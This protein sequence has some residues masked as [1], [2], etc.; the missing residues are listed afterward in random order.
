MFDFANSSFTTIIITVVFSVYFVN[1]IAA[2]SASANFLWSLANFVSQALV[3]LTAPVLGAIADF[4][5]AKKKFLFASY[6][7]CVVFTA[8]LYLTGPGQVALALPLFIIAN[9]AY[10]SGENLIASFLPEIAR[11]QDMGKISGFGWALGFIGGVVSL[12]LCYSFIKGGFTLA[13]EHNVR[14]TCLVTAGF[15]LLAGIPTFFW[16]KERKQSE[17]LPPG[18]SHVGMGCRRIRDTFQHVR[19]FRELF[20]FLIIFCMYNCGVTTVVVFASIYAEQV[21]H[22]QPGELIIFFLITLRSHPGPDRS[23]KDDL[24]HP[25]SVARRHRRSLLDDRQDRLLCRRQSCRFGNRLQPVGGPRAGRALLAAGQERRVLWVLGAVVEIINGAGA[26]GVRLRL[27]PDGLDAS[28]NPGD[29]RFLR[30]WSSRSP[31]RQRTKRHSSRRRLR[32]HVATGSCLMSRAWRSLSVLRAFAVHSSP[33]RR[34]VREVSPR[35]CP[36]NIASP[37]LR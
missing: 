7:V 2:K 34:K 28:G 11:P 30:P 33:Q 13:N 3:L 14:M 26:A 20:K 18:S 32:S 12:L 36:L 24:H 17:Q 15:F 23:K 27:Q 10:S 6:A 19:L 31:V 29:R 35:F 5:G 9:Y 8:L 1:I 16:V 25:D 37:P 21:I 4:S 22:L